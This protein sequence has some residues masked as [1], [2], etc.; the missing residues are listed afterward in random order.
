MPRSTGAYP[1]TAGQ[2]RA[3]GSPGS[4]VPVCVPV[5]EDLVSFDE[6]EVVRFRVGDRIRF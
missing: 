3:A 2:K 4:V 5:F 1:I 6:Y